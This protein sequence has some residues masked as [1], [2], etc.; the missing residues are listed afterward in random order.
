MERKLNSHLPFGDRSTKHFSNAGE[1]PNIHESNLANL[2]I[3]R[4][5]S[6]FVRFLET[7]NDSWSPASLDEY[8]EN[9]PL[10]NDA[11][12][13]MPRGIIDIIPIPE[14]KGADSIIDGL[15]ERQD[16]L[17]REI[18][19]LHSLYRKQGTTNLAAARETMQILAENFDHVFSDGDTPGVARIRDLERLVVEG[20][21]I[22][23][24]EQV[25]GP[26]TSSGFPI[27][28]E[29]RDALVLYQSLQERF[30][31]KKQLEDVNAFFEK[32]TDILEAVLGIQKELCKEIGEYAKSSAVPE[33]NVAFSEIA[34]INEQS[35]E[36]MLSPRLLKIVAHN[37][38]RYFTAQPNGTISEILSSAITRAL[39][40]EI[41]MQ[42]I[43]VFRELEDGLGLY[44]ITPK[45]CP[46][47]TLIGRMIG[48]YLKD[49]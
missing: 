20:G 19:A 45:L 2:A 40:E 17:V 46:A 38:G 18:L 22:E 14:S 48:H 32:R 23:R 12:P 47:R 3:N 13:H 36:V 44:G 33:L 27:T 43:F 39:E 11:H 42:Q 5:L 10:A 8:N 26:D 28:Y 21:T 7:K 16:P 35:G 4:T 29:R 31:S 6:S 41:Y 1:A 34:I 30:E 37:W 15:N 49:K 25:T 9:A 24:A